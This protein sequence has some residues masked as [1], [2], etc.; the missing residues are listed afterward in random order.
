MA[1]LVYPQS[2][3][4]ESTNV[5]DSALDEWSDASV[6]YT[7]SDQVKLTTGQAVPHHFFQAL[8]NH[9]SAAGNAPVIGGNEYWDDLG[10]INR[11]KMFDGT[12]NNRTAA[13]SGEDIEVSI[14]PAGRARYLYLIGLR[15]CGTVTV[16][17]EVDST[18][19]STT[20]VDLT[21]SRNPVGPWAWLM[22][23]EGVDR[24]YSRSAAIK[25][26]G[27]YSSPTLNITLTSADGPAECGQVVVGIGFEI[28]DTDWEAEP[29]LRDFSTF[30]QD[31]TYGTTTFVPRQTTRSLNGTLWIDSTDY[32]RVYSLFE[33]RLNQLTLLDLNNEDSGDYS[34]DALRAYGKVDEV[35]GGIRYAKTPLNI[36][37]IGLS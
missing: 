37:L 34:L 24:Y 16:E 18:V 12:N 25:L 19:M 17:E 3:T 6:S 5:A 20:T 22:D 8:Q 14:T 4:L 7:I 33:T 1:R 28:G 35:S 23:I 13:D 15:N 30:E 29:E 9:T 31:D 36:R 26:P 27:D 11:H 10:A 2:L 21:R 32:D